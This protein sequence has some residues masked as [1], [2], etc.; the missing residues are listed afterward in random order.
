MLRHVQFRRTAQHIC[1]LSET[2]PKL[3]QIE[4]CGFSIKTAVILHILAIVYL[5]L[6]STQ[7]ESTDLPLRFL[8]LPP[9]PLCTPTRNVPWQFLCH[10]IALRDKGGKISESVFNHVAKPEIYYRDY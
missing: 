10:Q 9:D 4:G 5:D 6:S 7:S 3:D 1:T 8:E 2:I